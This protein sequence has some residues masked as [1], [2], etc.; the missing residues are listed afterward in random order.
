MEGRQGSRGRG[1]EDCRTC[2]E[3]GARGGQGREREKVG[4]PGT[5]R[6]TTWHPSITSCGISAAPDASPVAR[7]PVSHSDAGWGRRT[8]G[9]RAIGTAGGSHVT[10]HEGEGAVT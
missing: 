8:A 4:W 5:L 2:Q 3:R 7:P 10:S 9:P 1:R 6:L